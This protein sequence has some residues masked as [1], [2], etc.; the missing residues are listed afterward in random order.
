MKAKPLRNIAASVRARLAKMAKEKGEDFQ[1]LLVRYATE[2]FLYR[3][4]QSIYADK[5]V[6]KGAML[7]VA[8]A[9]WPYRPTR[10][11]D[12]LG[13]EK[14]TAAILAEI[15]SGICTV[16]VEEDVLLFHPHSVKVRAIRDDQEHGGVR[17]LITASLEQARIQVQIVV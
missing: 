16:Q 3:L 2:R 5:F 1:R 13:L 12:L 15:I 6:L 8:Q 7:F 17:A 4:Y 9:S 14:R 10:D 11:L